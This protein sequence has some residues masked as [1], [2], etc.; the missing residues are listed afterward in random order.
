[1]LPIIAHLL[2][3]YVLNVY[4]RPDA[5]LGAR[6]TVVNKSKNEPCLHGAYNTVGQS[7]INPSNHTHKNKIKT[8]L[9][10]KKKSSDKSIF[11][12]SFNLYG[13]WIK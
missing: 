2:S 11:I 9:N 8:A 6:N 1:M 13:R 7:A 4:H 3:K 12:G 5:M 10:A